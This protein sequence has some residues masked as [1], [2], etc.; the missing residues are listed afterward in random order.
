MIRALKKFTLRLIAGA[1]VATILILLLVGMA[2]FVNPVGHPR[3][4]VMGLLFPVLLLFN[5][6]FLVFWLVFKPKGALIPVLGFIVAYS[7]IRSYMPLNVRHEVPDSALKVISYNVENFGAVPGQPQ[8]DSPNEIVR[9]LAD[10]HADLICLQEAGG[11][12]VKQEID[13]VMGAV[14]PYRHI[15]LNDGNNNMLRLYSKFPIMSAERIPYPSAGNLSVA[16]QLNVN[17][18]IVLVINNHLE[19]NLLD[20]EDKAGFK[21]LVKGKL[22]EN[23]ARAES[24]RLIDKLGAAAVRRAPQAE[25][26]AEYI[27]RHRGMATIVCGDFNDSPLSYSCRTIGKG[28]TDCYRES[29]NGPGHSYHR[30]GMYVR[31]DH[32]YC[33]RDWKPY[34]C[35]V[36]SKIK[37]SDHYPIVGWLKMQ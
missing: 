6:A 23:R 13:S 11:L 30:S 7:P 34:R 2:G 25:A 29:G 1:N 22:D 16:Y 19:S 8:P 4:S 12:H 35:F 31:I 36:D 18:Q 17:H 20:V 21:D 3:L 28:L 32:L 33:S 24:T 26:V 14:Y 27:R 5:F 9:Y 15:Q 37:L 10:S